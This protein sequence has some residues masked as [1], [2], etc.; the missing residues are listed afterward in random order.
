MQWEEPVFYEVRLD[1]DMSVHG[2][3]T[4]GAYETERG[5]YPELDLDASS[6]AHL[7]S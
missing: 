3:E 5:S 1:A 7:L 2:E 6:L 4:Q